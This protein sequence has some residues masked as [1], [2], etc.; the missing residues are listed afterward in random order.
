MPANGEPWQLTPGGLIDDRE[1]SPGRED[2]TI[3]G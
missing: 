1:V 2:L 3:K